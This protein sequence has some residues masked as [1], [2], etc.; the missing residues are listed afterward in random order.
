MPSIPCRNI[1][2]KMTF[3]QMSEGQK[4]TLPQN[5]FIMRPVAFGNQK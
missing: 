1:G 2:R 5:S 4:C 3:M